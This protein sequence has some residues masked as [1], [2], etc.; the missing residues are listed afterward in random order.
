MKQERVNQ[1][2]QKQQLLETDLRIYKLLKLPENLKKN[3]PKAI[4]FSHP[5]HHKYHHWS[6]W[7]YEACLIA[8]SRSHLNHG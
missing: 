2:Q 3:M 6:V 1:N 5:H 8:C 7:I 4:L